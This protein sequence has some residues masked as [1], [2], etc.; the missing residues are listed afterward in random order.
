MNVS[1]KMFL[2]SFPIPCPGTRA[3]S[4]LLCPQAGI[5]MVTFYF[6]ETHHVTILTEAPHLPGL[7][8]A[9]TPTMVLRRPTTLQ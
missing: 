2:T 1:L 8:P 3:G 5:A 9:F 6:A 4:N 7:T